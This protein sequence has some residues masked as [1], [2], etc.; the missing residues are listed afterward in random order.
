MELIETA[1]S[2]APGA[3]AWGKIE[4]HCQE[5]IASDPVTFTTRDSHLVSMRVCATPQ[6]LY[7]SNSDAPHVHSSDSTYLTSLDSRPSLIIPHPG[8]Q[9]SISCARAEARLPQESNVR[10]PRVIVIR[11]TPCNSAIAP[12]PHPPIHPLAHSPTRHSSRPHRPTYK[13]PV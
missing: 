10:A 11:A 9:V 4:F 5:P 12:P 6:T 3:A 2:G 7:L 13:L 1:R 8:A